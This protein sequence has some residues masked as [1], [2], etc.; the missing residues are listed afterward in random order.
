MVPVSLTRCTV[1]EVGAVEDVCVLEVRLEGLLAVHVAVRHVFHLARLDHL[2]PL[3][4][5]PAELLQLNLLGPLVIM[6]LEVAG[7]S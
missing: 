1:E 5:V 6:L 2:Q 3:G 7:Q 4:V